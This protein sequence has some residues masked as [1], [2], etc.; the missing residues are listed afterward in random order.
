MKPSLAGGVTFGYFPTLVQP[1]AGRGQHKARI[2]PVVTSG[3]AAA[4][5]GACSRPAGAA[6]RRISAASEN[7]QHFRDDR[8]G[9]TGIDTG[10]PGGRTHLHAFSAASAAVENV[11]YPNVQC[12]DKGVGTVGHV[13]LVQTS[14]DS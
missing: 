5:A 3:E 12:G 10:R 9:L 4:G 2:D 14:C 6:A 13:F 7:V 1:Q 11:A 8:D